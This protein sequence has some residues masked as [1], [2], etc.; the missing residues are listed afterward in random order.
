M[1]KPLTLHDLKPGMIAILIDKMEYEAD[2]H[3]GK[4]NV[5]PKRV[6][7]KYYSE[8]WHAVVDGN[9]SNKYLNTVLF[10]EIKQDNDVDRGKLKSGEFRF[11]AME[12][13]IFDSDPIVSITILEDKELRIIISNDGQRA[14]LVDKK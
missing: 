8:E 3:S 11:Q 5:A 4:K 13:D 9:Y 14:K 1:A 7:K 10:K 6:K 12:K 2:E